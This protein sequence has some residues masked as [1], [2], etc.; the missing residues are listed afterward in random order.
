MGRIL[1]IAVD[2]FSFKLIANSENP[3]MKIHA[4]NILKN[5]ELD[6]RKLEIHE[7]DKCRNKT[8]RRLNA[9]VINTVDL[10]DFLI[11]NLKVNDFVLVRRQ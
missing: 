2:N 1:K 11:V 3:H 8:G 10:K 6:G 9:S 7:V 5:Y 4:D